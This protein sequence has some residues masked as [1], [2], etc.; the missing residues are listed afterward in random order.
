MSGVDELVR[1]LI[2]QGAEREATTSVS[3]CNPAVTILYCWEIVFS[4]EYWH[5]ATYLILLQLGYTALHLASWLG[6]SD[7]VSTLLQEIPSLHGSSARADLL[8]TADGHTSLHLAVTSGTVET[9]AL[10]LED[11]AS[12][13]N[14]A[15]PVSF[16][17]ITLTTLAT[18]TTAAILYVCYIITDSWNFCTLQCLIPIK[19]LLCTD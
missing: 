8:L 18:I 16:L 2:Q 4:S 9:V 19:F 17:L 6:Y 12:D 15:D 14:T 3:S 11:D 10:L 1:L 7:I 5:Y 13:A